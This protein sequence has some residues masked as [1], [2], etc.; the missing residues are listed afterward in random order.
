MIRRFPIEYDKALSNACIH[1]PDQSDSLQQLQQFDNWNVLLSN[2]Y[3]EVMASNSTLLCAL[4]D[5]H[6][7]VHS[8]L[9]NNWTSHLI[10]IQQCFYLN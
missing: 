6:C 10:R 2:L 3:F 5:H 7:F 4:H 9:H 8:C 1:L